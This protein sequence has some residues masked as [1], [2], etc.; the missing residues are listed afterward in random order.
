VGPLVELPM[1]SIMAQM[2][3]DSARGTN[4]RGIHVSWVAMAEGVAY[5]SSKAA[6]AK[7]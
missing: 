4:E 2:V 6:N 3:G 7:N 5:S 1:I